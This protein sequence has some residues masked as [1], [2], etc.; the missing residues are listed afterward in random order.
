MA[1]RNFKE[2]SRY[3]AAAF[4]LIATGLAVFGGMQFTDDVA[5]TSPAT[6]RSLEPVQQDGNLAGS[7]MPAENDNSGTSTIF[8]ESL[9]LARESRGQQDGKTASAAAVLSTEPNSLTREKL[10]QRLD[11][12][13]KAYNT[14][15]GAAMER[16]LWK[17]HAV[18]RPN[19]K[20]MY[21]SDLMGQWATEWVQFRNRS[22]SFAIEHIEEEG[23]N[24]TAL[25]SVELTA[26]LLDAA[27]EAHKLEFNGT[28]K[29]VYVRSGEDEM[30]DGPITYVRLDQ[31][32]D[33]YTTRADQ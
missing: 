9:A 24:V 14:G 21:R 10:Q 18:T 33:G 29:A 2:S 6:T 19:G 22:L 25:W 3:V 5:A 26:D 30:L 31:T 32:I 8:A 28:Q 17:N 11:A 15:D 4:A 23:T 20:T 12:I 16:A 13:A 27:G 1:V 7:A